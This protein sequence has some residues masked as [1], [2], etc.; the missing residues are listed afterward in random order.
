MSV[1]TDLASWFDRLDAN[2]KEEVI[3]FLYGG[4][5]LLKEGT[6]VGRYPNAIAKGLHCGPIPRLSANACPTCGKLW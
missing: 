5:I 3:K 1:V 4:K 2:E 6:Y